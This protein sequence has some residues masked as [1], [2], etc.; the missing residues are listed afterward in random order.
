MCWL[1]ICVF[2]HQFPR[3]AIW[4]SFTK[5]FFI[6][7]NVGQQFRPRLKSLSMKSSVL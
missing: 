4:L 2:R 5:L 6:L 7:Q 1:E 3:Q